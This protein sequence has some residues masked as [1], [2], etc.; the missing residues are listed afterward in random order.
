MSHVL[1][2]IKLPELLKA[3]AGGLQ[4]SLPLNLCKEGPIGFIIH[5]SIQ[6]AP[7]RGNKN[8]DPHR[9]VTKAGRVNIITCGASCSALSGRPP[10]IG[11]PNVNPF[12]ISHFLTNLLQNDVV[13]V[14]ACSSL[15]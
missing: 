2:S 11:R 10:A 15:L 3:S 7:L 14:A 4:Q 12:W 13:N 1:A 6:S 9:R 8:D 5:N